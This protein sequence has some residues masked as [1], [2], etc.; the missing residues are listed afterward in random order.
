VDALAAPGAIDEPLA[1]TLAD[2]GPWGAGRPRPVLALETVTLESCVPVGA[3]DSLRLRV[4]GLGGPALDV[5]AFRAAGPLGERLRRAR[6]EALHM[7]VEV[8]HG[9]FRGV[10]RAE[11]S[12]VD[13][14]DAA[15]HMRRAA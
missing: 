2:L 10:P 11:A 8:S 6:S 7:A 9:V 15:A 4:R 14:A 13:L 12:L 3:G 1:R 5:M